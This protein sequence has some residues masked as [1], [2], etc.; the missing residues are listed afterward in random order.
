M[1]NMCLKYIFLFCLCLQGV[2]LNSQNLVPNGNFE[3]HATFDLSVGPGSY[4]SYLSDWEPTG[5]AT[6]E[7]YA[8]REFVRKF[9]QQRL[10]DCGYVNFDT[11]N[12]R[13]GDAMV[14]LYYGENLKLQSN[15]SIKRTQSITWRLRNTWSEMNIRRFLKLGG[16]SPGH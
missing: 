2:P 7:V 3:K 16:D 6:F 15:N 8:H 13:N 5:M 10:K 14:K 11:L 4:I 12:L 1:K 9:G